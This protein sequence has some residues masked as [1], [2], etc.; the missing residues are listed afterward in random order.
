M[1]LIEKTSLDLII[2][3]I[4]E[5]NFSLSTS[6]LPQ[7]TKYFVVCVVTERHLTLT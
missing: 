7:T 1:K 6:L 5:K 2:I 3:S 4:L